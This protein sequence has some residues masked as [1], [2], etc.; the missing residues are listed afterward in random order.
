M[1]MLI[2]SKLGYW[3]GIS[4]TGNIAKKYKIQEV[5]KRDGFV[6]DTM[7]VVD[8]DD[9]QLLYNDFYM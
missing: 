5:R 2:L 7:T 6:G 9:A 4:P 1:T 8:A 3:G